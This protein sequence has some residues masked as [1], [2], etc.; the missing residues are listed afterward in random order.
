LQDWQLLIEQFS[1]DHYLKGGEGAKQEFKG[2][3]EYAL[4]AFVDKIAVFVYCILF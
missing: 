3:L 4:R 1:K 2:A